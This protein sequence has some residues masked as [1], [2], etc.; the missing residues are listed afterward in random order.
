MK[1]IIKYAAS[2]FM[3]LLL[4][5][6]C[7]KYLDVQPKG[8]QLLK[9]VNDYEL[10]LNSPDLTYQTGAYKLFVFT[11]L[12]DNYPLVLTST[13]SSDLRYRWAPQFNAASVSPEIWSDFYTHIYYY[14]AVLNG[15]DN[16]TGGTEQQKSKLKAEALL[17]RA[18]E[19]FYLMNLYAKVYDPAT[20]TQDLS[21]PFVQ[22]SDIV[23]KTPP[24]STVKEGYDKIISDLNE[25][26]KL[27]PA[28]NATNRFRGS[29][30]AAYSMLARTYFYMRDYNNAQKYAQ[31]ALQTPSLTMLDYKTGVVSPTIFPKWPAISTRKDV[32]YARGA[33]LRRYAAYATITL[34]FAKSFAT[35]DMRSY[36]IKDLYNSTLSSNLKRGNVMYCYAYPLGGA[37]DANQANIGP[38]VAE[39]KLIIAE[40]AARSGDLTTALQQL[41]DVRINRFERTN[42][43][44]F[45]S[46]DPDEVL[47][48]VL[49]E[50][51]FELPFSSLRWLDMR[52]LDAE[53]RMPAVNRY[54]DTGAVFETLK[55]KDPR[56]VLQIPLNV[57]NYNPDM[58][59]NP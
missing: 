23:T 57:L 27:L 46:G 44:K 28:D 52:R 38:S 55:P 17:G 2:L 39:M 25:A 12:Y 8:K 35:G 43:V 18:F 5:T 21:V 14:N 3:C 54:D 22:S 15:I 24:R 36:L 51:V 41:D 50:R 1:N 34:S 40:V 4:F 31:L 11:D 33:G 58:P 7:K 45:Q 56:Y 13:N 49:D 47:Q 30:P 16:A 53:G 10:W 37:S 42:Y 29:V 19:Y 26:I 20:A 59:Q 9:T 32:I 6:G 48:K